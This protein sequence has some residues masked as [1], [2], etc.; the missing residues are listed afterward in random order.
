MR[1][2]ESDW[3]KRRGREGRRE[4]KEDAALETNMLVMS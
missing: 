2:R 1:R 3:T 4:K